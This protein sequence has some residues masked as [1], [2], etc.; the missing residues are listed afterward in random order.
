MS[1]PASTP[2][3][4]PQAIPAEVSILNS[5]I[6]SICGEYLKEREDCPGLPLLMEAALISNSRIH[7]MLSEYVDSIPGKFCLI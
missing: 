1:L 5:L 2:L 7:I 3:L 4:S 6:E